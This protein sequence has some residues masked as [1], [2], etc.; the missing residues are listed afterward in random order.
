MF[1]VF[2][3]HFHVMCICHLLLDINYYLHTQVLQ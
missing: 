2:F 1:A 3:T